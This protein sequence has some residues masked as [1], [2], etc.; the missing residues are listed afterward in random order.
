MNQHDFHVYHRKLLAL[1]SLAQYSLQRFLCC[2]SLKSM[3]FIDQADEDAFNKETKENKE[4]LAISKVFSQNKDKVKKLS[5]LFTERVNVELI[6]K[7]FAN[8]VLNDKIDA[9][10]LD[11]SAL[12]EILLGIKSFPVSYQTNRKEFTCKSGTHTTDTNCCPACVGPNHCCSKCKKE[13]C[14]GKCCE[15]NSTCSHPCKNCTQDTLECLNF[16]YVCCK[17]CGV[18]MKCVLK[19]YKLT[20]W[21]ELLQKLVNGELITVCEI[22]LLRLSISIIRNFRNLMSHLTTEKCTQ[23]DN[24]TFTDSKIPSFCTSWEKLRD[25]FKF[26]IK[27]LLNYLVSEKTIEDME[28]RE[29]N[30]YLREVTISAKRHTD[31]DIY[32]N[33]INRYLE[34]EQ[35]SINRIEEKMDNINI[36]LKSVA[37]NQKSLAEKSLKVDVKYKSKVPIEFDLEDCTEENQ[38]N[39]ICKLIEEFTKTVIR[40]FITQVSVIF[41]GAE[42]QSVDQKVHTLKFKIT[43]KSEGMNF[44]DYENYRGNDKAKNLWKRLKEELEKDLPEGTKLRLKLWDVSSIII[45]A[46]I[47]KAS[48]QEWMEEEISEIDKKISDFSKKF[49]TYFIGELSRCVMAFESERNIFSSQS[50]VF[51][52]NDINIDAVE[53]LDNEN[54]IRHLNLWLGKKISIKGK[55]DTMAE[56]VF[57]SI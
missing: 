56:V 3:T 40:Y 55:I 20:H 57:L 52:I 5:N 19:K 29:H 32:R 26:S 51:R 34:L 21:H 45:I 49:D 37:E 47:R 43:S 12:A 54:F 11:T 14:K 53:K 35:F 6:Y 25:V 33:R 36:N 9:T 8:E 24:G 28:F 15:S 23:M 10:L 1:G 31:L 4:A 27:N 38:E 50:L 46:T 17:T 41:V 13:R 42:N 44:I 48:D 7:N 22:F 30:E 16:R 39:P 18:C 2:L